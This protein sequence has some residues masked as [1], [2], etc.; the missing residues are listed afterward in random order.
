MQEG[1]QLSGACGRRMEWNGGRSEPVEIRDMSCCLQSDSELDVQSLRLT[2]R[3]T[4]IL[5]LNRA[6]VMIRP[7]K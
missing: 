5:S 4:T 7:L 3:I 1:T 2:Y 6:A